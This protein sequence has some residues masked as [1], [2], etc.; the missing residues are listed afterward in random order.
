MK[1]SAYV[2]VR[3]GLSAG[4]RVIVA[5]IGELKAGAIATVRGEGA[6]ASGVASEVARR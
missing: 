2:E 6:T 4:D 1:G 5:N 3:D